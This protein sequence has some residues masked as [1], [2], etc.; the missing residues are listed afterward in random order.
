MTVKRCDEVEKVIGVEA[1]VVVE[2]IVKVVAFV[3]FNDAVALNVT[4][5][6]LIDI[7]VSFGDR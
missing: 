3:T 1:Y 5:G 7:E 4:F 2:V 6:A